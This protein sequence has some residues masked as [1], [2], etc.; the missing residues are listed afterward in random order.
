VT[1]LKEHKW[2]EK[3]GDLLED[4]LLEMRTILEM[5]NEKIVARSK[6]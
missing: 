1:A 6:L 2:A 5:D 4:A 3:L